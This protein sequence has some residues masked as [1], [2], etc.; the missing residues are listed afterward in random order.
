MSL[1]VPEPSPPLRA[2]T[3]PPRWPWPAPGHIYN[4][5]DL[6]GHLRIAIEIGEKTCGSEPML[7][8]VRLVMDALQ[9]AHDEQVAEVAARMAQP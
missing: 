5:S 3:S 1:L 8:R 2:V 9:R 4:P 6:A 7:T